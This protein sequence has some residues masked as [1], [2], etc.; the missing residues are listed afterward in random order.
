[1]RIMQKAAFQHRF[2]EL[3]VVVLADLVSRLLY[4]INLSLLPP[5]HSLIPFQEMLVYSF[6]V[7]LQPFK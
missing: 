1:M 2:E 4:C 5:P 7:Q 3:N 6:S